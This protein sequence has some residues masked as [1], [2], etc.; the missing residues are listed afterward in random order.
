MSRLKTGA[1]IRA[2]MV[3]AE[4]MLNAYR[5]RVERLERDVAVEAEKRLQLL[6]KRRKTSETAISQNSEDGESPRELQS[7]VATMPVKLRE[8][9]E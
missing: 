7:K 1:S 4:E 3:A 5:A 6:T 8:W 2:Q 9:C